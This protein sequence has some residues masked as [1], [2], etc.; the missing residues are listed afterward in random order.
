MAKATA[1]A[2]ADTAVDA[3]LID[4]R[5]FGSKIVDKLKYSIGK[6]LS[7]QNR[8]FILRHDPCAA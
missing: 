6:D 3:T 1:T 7:L 4:R 2:T 8:T 5:T